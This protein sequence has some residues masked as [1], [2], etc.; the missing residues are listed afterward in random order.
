MYLNL[1]KNRDQFINDAVSICNT[2]FV[3]TVEKKNI[4]QL[5]FKYKMI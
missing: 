2:K 1:K 3:N 5:K 4:I